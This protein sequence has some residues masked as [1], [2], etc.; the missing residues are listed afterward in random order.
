MRRGFSFLNC[1]FFLCEEECSLQKKVEKIYIDDNNNNIPVTKK[2]LHNDHKSGGSSFPHSSHGALF[3]DTL[4][5]HATLPFLHLM[6]LHIILTLRIV[7][8]KRFL[9]FL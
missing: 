2:E 7:S 8:I 1:N 6:M 3:N 9:I 5:V 4:R